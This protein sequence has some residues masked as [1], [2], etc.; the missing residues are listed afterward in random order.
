MRLVVD[1]GRAGSSA[2]G[3]WDVPA[4]GPGT[5]L[6]ACSARFPAGAGL[7]P[8]H[9]R[10]MHRWPAGSVIPAESAAAVSGGA[11][12]G[13]IACAGM[14]TGLLLAPGRLE[15]TGFA[16]PGQRR[17]KA[18]PP[19]SLAAAPVGCQHQG[20]AGNR[21]GRRGPLSAPIP[22][23]APP[24]AA[25]TAGFSLWRPGA[26]GRPA[27]SAGRPRRTP[28]SA[29]AGGHAAR[30]RRRSSCRW[31]RRPPAAAG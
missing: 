15:A 27:R 13:R 22:G 14:L 7:S 25:G 6:Q 31:P 2:A 20:R 18:A 26:P 30:T 17:R 19:G 21:A 11:A 8:P 10:A 12:G 3:V 4:A 16:G 29:R 1:S 23:E 9:E 5:R 28:G 24:P